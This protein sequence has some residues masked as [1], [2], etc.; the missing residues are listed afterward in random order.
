MAHLRVITSKGADATLG[1]SV[2][3]KF[4]SKLRG[5]SLRPGK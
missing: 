3:E 4:A 5:G 2:I 1:E